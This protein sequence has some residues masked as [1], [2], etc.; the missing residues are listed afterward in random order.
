MKYETSSYGRENPVYRFI[1]A[2][3]DFLESVESDVHYSIKHYPDRP[4][5][6]C[7][8]VSL[9][10]LKCE[11]VDACYKDLVGKERCT[12][13][14]GIQDKYSFTAAMNDLTSCFHR[15]ID[16]LE[17]YEV[18]EDINKDG[19]CVWVKNS[20]KSLIEAC[21]E[22]DKTTEK[23]NDNKLYDGT[24]YDEL[25]GI[26]RG[27]KVEFRVGSSAGH[28]THIDLERGMVEYY[29]TD[30]SV[31]KEMKKLLEKEGL[32]C[33]KY[34]EDRTEAGIKC[35]GLTEQNVKNVVKKLAGATS[36]DFRIPAPGLWWRGTAKKHPEILGCEDEAC[37]IE[38]KLKEEK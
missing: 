18:D 31:N 16:M 7:E 24:D 38:I 32:K 4:L 25:T 9:A 26:V 22:W 34:L 10:R 21:K 23:F 2:L 13:L 27:N 30:V 20:N 3:Y 15:L 11:S 17:K 37:R 12:Y 36:M 19:K 8:S 6:E 35:T 28:K 33:Y 14:C 29:D 5:K 1:E